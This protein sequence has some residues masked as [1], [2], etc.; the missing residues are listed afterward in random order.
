MNQTLNVKKKK[1]RKTLSEHIIKRNKLVCVPVK[2]RH[3]LHTTYKKKKKKKKDS[4]CCSFLPTSKSTL[5]P[6]GGATLKD[7]VATFKVRFSGHFR[8]A[9]AQLVRL[10]SSFNGC[11]IS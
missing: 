10:S 3:S 4:F 9:Q 7:R 11:P 8:T 2:V 1:K 6:D 5:W